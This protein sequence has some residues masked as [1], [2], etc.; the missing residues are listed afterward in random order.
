MLHNKDFKKS[1]ARNRH[2]WLTVRARVSGEKEDAVE[3][4]A[5]LE[6]TDGVN[7]WNV[8]L[9]KLKLNPCSVAN[10]N[11]APFFSKKLLNHFA[12]P[13]GRGLIVT[14]FGSVKVNQKIR[15]KNFVCVDCCSDFFWLKL[16]HHLGCGLFTIQSAVPPECVGT[17]LNQPPAIASL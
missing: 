12:P 11:R 5:Q 13:M 16:E 9:C 10:N 3:R 8:Q 7:V 15:L 2:M 1:T 17:T 14:C 4:R 6:W